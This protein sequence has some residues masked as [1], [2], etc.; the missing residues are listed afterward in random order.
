M[1]GDCDFVVTVTIVKLEASDT[2]YL[3]IVLSSKYLP[4]L[5]RAKR[6]KVSVLMLIGI[7]MMIFLSASVFSV[8]SSLLLAG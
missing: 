8:V 6:N 3:A 4:F 5:G 2:W 7:F 1:M